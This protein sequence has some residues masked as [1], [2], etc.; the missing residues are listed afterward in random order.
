MPRTAITAI[1]LINVVVFVAEVVDRSADGDRSDGSVVEWLAVHSH[2]NPPEKSLA[3][4]SPA[5]REKLEPLYN[6]REDTLLHPWLWWQFLTCGFVHDP[7]EMQHIMFNML[8]LFFLG[9]DVEQW[10]GTREFVRLYLV[11]LVFSALVW[12]AVDRI[13][14]GSF[15]STTL[16]DGTTVVLPLRTTLFGASGAITGVVLLYALLFP[17]RTLLLMF[18]LPLPAW[19]LGAMAI[20]YDIIGAMGRADQHVAYVCHLGGAAFALAYF[21]FRWNLGNAFRPVVAWVKNRARP[22]LKVFKPDDGPGGPVQDDEV[23]RILTKIH[24]EG[25]QSLTPK[26]RRFMENASREYQRRRRGPE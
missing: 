14:P 15:P 19:L 16:P 3:Q 20:A 13:F 4:L 6:P 7:R 11:I 22:P 12:S 24:R 18:V 2:I 21:N 25:E 8:T 23:D 17:R 10:Y 1:I 26:E 9:R 5:A